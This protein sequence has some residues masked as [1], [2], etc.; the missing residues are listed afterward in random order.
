LLAH[1]AFISSYV[2]ELFR[3]AAA[4]SVCVVSADVDDHI[5]WRM[6]V[7]IPKRK[8]GFGT[9]PLPGYEPNTGFRA[10]MVPFEAMPSTIDPTEGFVATAN[11]AP[12]PHA[13]APFLGVDWLD[14]YRH[15]SIVDA[16]SARRDWDVEST[17]T[18]QKGVRSIPWEEIRDVVLAAPREEVA[19]RALDL[20]SAWDGQMAA[21]S[22]GASVYALFI[23]HLTRRFVE[24][25]APVT[26]KRV[27][28]E[29]FNPMLPHN[30]LIGRRLGHV[31]ELVLEQ[32][33]G[34]FDA[35]WPA[36]IARALAAAVTD[37]E[38]RRGPDTAR[39][40]WGEVRPLRLVHLFSRV[41]P[42]LDRVFGLGPFPGRGDSS[43]IVQGTIDLLDPTG[44]PLG[45][46]NLRV[47]I[48]LADLRAS[49]FSIL[50]GQSGNPTSPLYGDQIGA[51]EA[52]GLTLAWTDEDVRDLS[53]HELRLSPA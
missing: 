35:G 42:L 15:R 1:T 23:A 25:V 31:V 29:G 27:L 49:R 37:L 11:N 10:E 18:L 36:E 14:G 8:R 47:V 51:F 16:L 7:E 43:T 3:E 9:I 2:Q 4:S 52:E 38:A 30:T 39:W 40:A 20:L 6:A 45:V 13:D 5:G 12:Q 46:P 32:P 33:A 44:N 22:V 24:V 19:A 53:A 48:D 34:I 17:L 26:A 21:E 28:G 50:G 41:N